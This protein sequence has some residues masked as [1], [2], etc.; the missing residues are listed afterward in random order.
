VQVDFIGILSWNHRERKLGEEKYLG[1]EGRNK[2]EYFTD[3]SLGPETIE[4][5]LRKHAQ[6]MNKLFSTN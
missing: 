6:I 2:S 1:K 4:N 3:F 5:S